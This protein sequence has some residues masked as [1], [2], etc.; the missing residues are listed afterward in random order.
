MLVPSL[1]YIKLIW[2]YIDIYFH[3]I[4]NLNIF[5]L[6][7]KDEKYEKLVSTVWLEMTWDDVRFKWDPADY[8]NIT[9]I[10][11]PASKLWVMNFFCIQNIS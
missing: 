9:E 5:D 7:S 10:T 2:Y 4:I 11:L 8:D 3:F 1:K 6:T